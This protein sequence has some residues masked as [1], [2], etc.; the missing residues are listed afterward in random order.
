MWELEL[1]LPELM[2]CPRMDV[3]MLQNH[4]KTVRMSPIIYQTSSFP[5]SNAPVSGSTLLNHQVCLTDHEMTGP[6]RA[7]NLRAY[8]R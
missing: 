5:D 7:C 2:K 4:E 1:E 6:L 8:S 3:V